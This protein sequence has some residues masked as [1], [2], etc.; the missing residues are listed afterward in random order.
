MSSS[1]RR[2]YSFLHLQRTSMRKPHAFVALL[3]TISLVFGGLM[4][5]SPAN[6]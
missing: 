4:L 2:R 1:D 5:S 6:R 3:A